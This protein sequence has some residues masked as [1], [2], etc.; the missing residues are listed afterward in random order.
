MYTKV[1][2]GNNKMR[3]ETRIGILAILIFQIA[4]RFFSFPDF[5]AGIVQGSGMCLILIGILPDITYEKLK[6]WKRSLFK[7]K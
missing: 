5:I 7:S 1:K 4:S 3:K 2:G 6:G